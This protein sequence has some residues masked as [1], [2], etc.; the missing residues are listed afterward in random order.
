MN[1]GNG[2]DSQDFLGEGFLRLDDDLVVAKA[3]KIAWGDGYNMMTDAKKIKYLEKLASTMNHAAYLVQSERD[4]LVKL[5]DEKELKV[6]SLSESLNA[7]ND[8]I[9]QQ[10]TKMNEEKQKFLKSIA[11]LKAT[12]REYEND[13][14]GSL[15]D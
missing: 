6:R 2:K 7:N 13:N 10:I 15:G 14:I 8:M 11:S 1:N 5:Y 3:P 12:I 9:Q 4:D